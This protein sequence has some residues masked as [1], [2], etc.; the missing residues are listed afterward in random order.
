MYFDYMPTMRYRE[1]EKYAYKSVNLK[2]NFVPLFEFVSKTQRTKDTIENF[3]RDTKHE[4]A[5]LIDV[6]L[7]LPMKTQTDPKARELIAPM[8]ANHQEKAD[9]L[10]DKRLIEEDKYIPVVS[11]DPHVPY[12]SRE[13]IKQIN[14]FK[15]HYN[16][17]AYR[18]HYKNLSDFLDQAN[19]HLNSNDILILDLD[20]ASQA[21]PKFK[22][23]HK[24]IVELSKKYNIVSVI[25]RSAIPDETTNTG[26]EDDEILDTADNSLLEN[27]S[28]YGYD[29]F[30]DYVGVKKDTLTSGGRISPGYLFYS[31][32]ENSFY[33]YKGVL[34]DASSFT[35][36]LVPEIMQSVPMKEFSEEHKRS[37]YGCC[38][39]IEIHKGKKKGNSQPAWKGYAAGHYLQT[40][41]EFL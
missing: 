4:R 37:C 21:H 2:D 6:P 27:Y 31:W 22:K 32:E 41:N 15:K 38:S 28:E 10:C 40:L 36:V 8:K 39:I 12:Q 9:F 1:Q 24:Q 25:L 33:G 14:T 17:L 16:K 34:N 29:A 11:Y 35:N 5:V 20:E 13:V 23:A 7:Y 18:A 30:G 19:D 3:V 26:L